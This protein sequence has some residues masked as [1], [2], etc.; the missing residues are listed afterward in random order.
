MTFSTAA[1]IAKL[2]IR[3]KRYDAV[4]AVFPGL[5]V[6][7]TPNGAKSFSLLFRL[8]GERTRRRITIG[9]VGAL[10]LASARLLA[11]KALVAAADGIDPSRERRL[12]RHRERE[13]MA[14]RTVAELGAEYLADAETRNAKTTMREYH[15]QWKQHVLGALGSLNASAVTIKEVA[16]L[17][18]SLH[19]TPVLANRGVILVNAFMTWCEREGI[20][21]RGSNPAVDVKRY[22]ET[23]IVRRLTDGEEVRL[24]AS[25][26][27]AAKTGNPFTIGAIRFLALTG[28][29]EQEALS[30]RWD[31]L[32]IEDRNCAWATLER[33]KTGKSERVLSTVVV[34]LLKSLPRT[35]GH[36]YVFESPAHP[37]NPKDPRR[38]L[39]AGGR[40]SRSKS[41]TPPK[42]REPGL[43]P[44]ASVERAWRKI[45]DEAKLTE[46]RLHD[47]RH[48]AVSRM[49]EAGASIAE[50]G[51]VAGHRTHS[52]TAKYT[53]PLEKGQRR[54]V[55]RF[56]ARMLQSATAQISQ[57]KPVRRKRAAS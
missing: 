17:H 56:A 22:K 37:A 35:V 5:R 45:R 31:A 54:A 28:W 4:D 44:I 2:P 27:N 19:L 13:A 9:N 49:I 11:R 29:R 33:T 55:E 24:M 25:M 1:E 12:R 50:A 43:H 57:R 42:R 16:A 21:P 34:D 26:E 32:D 53:H 38:I 30:L 41:A 18:R 3:A 14:E 15:R 23:S 51:G 36:P 7:V 8:K 47:L 10:D 46:F 48:S 52:T 6:R 39:A 20:R 40:K